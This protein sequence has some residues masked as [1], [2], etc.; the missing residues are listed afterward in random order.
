MTKMY[1][2]EK[3]V[4]VN[5]L[6]IS[7]LLKK[8]VFRVHVHPVIYNFR[9]GA[10]KKSYLSHTGDPQLPFAIWFFL[11]DKWNVKGPKLSIKKESDQQ[12]PA[13]GVIFNS[14]S[15][16]P[17][18]SVIS[19]MLLGNGHFEQTK[20]ANTPPTPAAPIR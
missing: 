19:S 7:N 9:T 16:T 4:I 18:V 3:T 5:E 11:P 8:Y 6:Q 13:P 17:R 12:L 10:Q 1:E 15:R 20:T 14:N 2:Q